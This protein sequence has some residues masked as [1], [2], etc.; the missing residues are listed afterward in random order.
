MP[1]RRRKR[2]SSRKARSYGD[3]GEGRG[4]CPDEI[5]PLRIGKG[6]VRRF[7]R[8]TQIIV[9]GLG[10]ELRSLPNPALSER[11]RSYERRRRL[12]PGSAR[13]PRAGRGVPP[14]VPPRRTSREGFDSARPI[15]LGARS[16]FRRDAETNSRDGCATRSWRL[17]RLHLPSESL[18]F[19]S[20]LL[21]GFG[22]SG[23][24]WLLY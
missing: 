8:R 24:A 3:R 23:Q 21:R 6:R 19:G 17:R 9:S 13:V 2:H 15:Q 16:S 22:A 7:R 14:G 20:F 5:D 11:M 10:T 4:D 12:L 1:R 18:P